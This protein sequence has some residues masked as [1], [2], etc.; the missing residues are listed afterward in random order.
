MT[1]CARN[2]DLPI[3][4][5]SFL[6]DTFD[7]ADRPVVPLGRMSAPTLVVARREVLAEMASATLFA[8]QRGLGHQFPQLPEIPLAPVNLPPP[9]GGEFFDSA[10][11][12]LGAAD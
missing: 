7:R 8:P 1:V 11:Q 9:I 3:Y 12:I 10:S 4:S 2:R 5:G 6:A